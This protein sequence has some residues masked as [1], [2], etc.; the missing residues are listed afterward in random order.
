M[1]NKRANITI[2]LLVIGI[3]A[4]FSLAILTFVS[5]SLKVGKSFEGVDSMKEINSE[6]NKYL[7]YSSEGINVEGVFDTRVNNLGDE[8]LYED[9]YGKK[10]FLNLGKEHLVFSVEWVFP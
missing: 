4:V 3:F 2:T 9:I 10:G 5:S 1:R 7:F 8:V 6:I